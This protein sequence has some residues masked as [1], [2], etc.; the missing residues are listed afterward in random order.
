M[1]SQTKGA[2]DLKILRLFLLAVVLAALSTGGYLLLKSGPST[3][4]SGTAAPQNGGKL[5]ATYRSEP[6]TFNR[7]VAPGSAEDLVAR[8]IHATLVRLDRTTGKVEPRLARSW[9]SSPDGLTWVFKLQEGITFSDGV[10]FT[11][12]D[13]VFSFR[14]LYDAKVNSEIASS[15]LI[16]GKP[17]QVRA[18]D[19]NTVS[20][21]FPSP[22][23]PGITL[24]DALPILPEH[25]LKAALDAG[26]FRDAWSV[27]SPLSDIV[28]L[29]PFVIQ[30][31]KAGQH[32]LFA[33]NPRFWGRDTAGRPQPLRPARRPRGR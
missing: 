3:T 29:G 9:T 7:Y 24:L 1:A 25:K 33:R 2:A 23:A 28:G 6:S 21:V 14:A 17:L 32:L 19:A 26:A 27:T 15:L 16:D 5:V 8:L 11:A 20:I 31:Y 30:E 10:P 22:Y 18:I 4:G 13:V 12:A